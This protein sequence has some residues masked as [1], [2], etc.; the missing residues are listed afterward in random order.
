MIFLG[1]LSVFVG[2]I[3]AVAVVVVARSLVEFPLLEITAA[4]VGAP[5][6][7]SFLWARLAY[8]AAAAGVGGFV[9]AW[10]AP[11]A[12][13]RHALVLTLPVAAPALLYALPEWP[14][15]PPGHDVAAVVL[16][17]AGVLVGAWLRGRIGS[18]RGRSG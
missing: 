7:R 10:L 9:T 2:W 1:A 6:P 15:E 11:E 18:G 13:L 14:A 16:P 17:V 4:E 5:V 12:P 8:G 3:T